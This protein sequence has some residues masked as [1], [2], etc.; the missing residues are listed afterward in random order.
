M[1]CFYCSM[2]IYCSALAQRILF[3][4]CTFNIPTVADFCPFFRFLKQLYALFPSDKSST[5]C[6]SIK[7]LSY[8]TLFLQIKNIIN[9]LHHHFLFIFSL[10][11]ISLNGCLLSNMLYYKKIHG[12][13]LRRENKIRIQTIYLI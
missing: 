9:L 8:L 12:L 5:P 3:V 2:K 7:R 11:A 10:N 4:N 6:L 1:T 13:I